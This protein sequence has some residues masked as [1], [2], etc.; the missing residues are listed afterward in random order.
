MRRIPALLV[1]LIAVPVLGCGGNG[2]H[3]TVG[4]TTLTPEEAIFFIATPVFSG[5]TPA[6]TPLPSLLVMEMAEQSDLCDAYRSGGVATNYFE[7]SLQDAASTVPS[8]AGIPTG[9][10]YVGDTS[11][12]LQASAYYRKSSSV[13]GQGSAGTVTLEAFEARANG[14]MTGSFQL[15]LSGNDDGTDPFQGTADVSG[16]FHATFCD[17]SN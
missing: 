9:T 1:V 6:L 10:Y 13:V 16:T 14:T 4:G 11:N 7:L 2:F 15:T 12:S 5:P 8:A 17:L 3:G